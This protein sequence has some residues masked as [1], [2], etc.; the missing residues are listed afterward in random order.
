M[1]L[2][3]ALAACGGDG[4]PT[5]TPG[6]RGLRFL[7]RSSIADT[8]FAFHQR[9]VVLELRDD[10]GAPIGGAPVT[11]ASAL[12]SSST[13]TAARFGTLPTGPTQ[14]TLT[15][16]T[17][18]SGRAQFFLQLSFKA[19]PGYVVAD[20]GGGRRDSIAVTVS[21]GTPVDLTVAPFDTAVLAG[22]EFQTRP[23]ARDLGGNDVGLP[24][25]L[26]S[27]TGAITV[28][29]GRIRGVTI[30]RAAV[31]ASLG[32]LRDTAWVSVVPPA[33]IAY[34]AAPIGAGQD[35]GVYL[36]DSDGSNGRFLYRTTGVIGGL[37]DF[38]GWPAWS[39]DAKQI[40]FVDG[41]LRILDVAGGTPRELVTGG[42]PVSDRYGPQM[43][44]LGRV[45]F[46]RG[47]LGSQHAVW[48]VPAMGGAAVQESPVLD[49]GVEAMPS[50]SPSGDLVAY[51][52]NR[53]SPSGVTFTLRLLD[54]V[55]GQVQALDVP[56]HSPRWS[57]TGDRIA[58]LDATGR[59]QF[60]SSTGATIASVS[61]GVAFAPGF[62]WSPDGEFIVGRGSA[63]LQILKISTREILPLAFQGPNG[64]ALVQP[65]W[66]P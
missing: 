34:H 18:E 32:V 24:I 33:T 51:Q 44:A 57:P 60:M 41:S 53:V 26:S 35:A 55:T 21:A 64:Q 20:A 8:I 4:G 15:V 29:A 58:Y 25:G 7:D 52:T 43:D 23:L 61:A 48:R 1:W 2:A 42:V 49:W 3:V 63:G 37:T 56:G 22:R 6:Q 11:L 28:A 66:K 13:I 65:S 62:S 31:I 5:A 46:T 9:S 19:G 47:T 14:P 40:A 12:T 45:H 39:A 16:T 54:P 27:T 59:V 50:P 30:G 38:G 36:L 17:D 10:A